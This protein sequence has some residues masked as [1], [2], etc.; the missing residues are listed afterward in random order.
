MTTEDRKECEYKVQALERALDVLECFSLQERE[1]NLSEVAAK[2][3]LNKTTAKRLISNLTRRGYLK[4]LD[5]KRY[6]LGLRLFELGSIVHSSLKL[7]Q[8]TSAPMSQIQ[9]ETGATV[10]LG[11]VMEDQLALIDKR[12]GRSFIRI[13][14]DV[15]WRGPLN[16]GML[17]MILMA[18]LE[19]DEVRR[20]LQK[21]KLQAYTPFSITDEDAFSLRLEHIRNQG[22]VIEKGEAMEGVVG[23]AAPIRDFSRQ[24]IAAL[25]VVLT[26]YQ[27]GNGMN[28]YIELVKGNC[29]KISREL[30]YL[31]I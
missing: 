21:D 12:E 25:G 3:G 24:V 20:I 6:Q 23:I 16:Y 14:A 13:S 22:Y 7:R 15:G 4:K 9:K 30:G 1:L 19:P 2:T 31:T 28:E 17:G 10:L 11:A 8:A 18:Y 5:S 29:E 26:N 27:P